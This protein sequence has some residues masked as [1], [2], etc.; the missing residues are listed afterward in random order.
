MPRVMFSEPRAP[1]RASGRPSSTA[2]RSAAVR[3]ERDSAVIVLT[4]ASDF[5]P[6]VVS[7]TPVPSR[8]RRYLH[9]SPIGTA[10][11]LA[12]LLQAPVSSSVHPNNEP[13]RPLLRTPGACL[14]KVSRKDQEALQ[15]LPSCAS[16]QRN[17]LDT[18]HSILLTR[19]PLA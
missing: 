13:F 7:Q 11:W 14:K 16:S 19:R 17:R 3:G 8:R 6:A 5:S 1:G 12:A 10:F 2:A 15:C 9:I 18:K 4:E